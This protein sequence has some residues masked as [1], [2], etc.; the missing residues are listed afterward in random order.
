MSGAEIV[1]TLVPPPQF[2][3]A[4][5]ESYRPDPQHPSQEEARATLRE[6]ASF[7]P[8]QRAHKSPRSFFGFGRRKQKTPTA[9]QSTASQ[10]AP[11]Q[12][13]VYLDGGFGVGKT[14]LLAAIWHAQEGKKYFGTF[15]EYTALVGALGYDGAVQSLK[16]ADLVCID[17]FELDD[18]GDTMLMTRLIRDLTDAGAKIV[19]TSNTPPNALGEGRFAAADFMREIHAMSD[20]FRTLRIDGQDYRQRNI[21]GSAVQYSEEEYEQ[22]LSSIAKRLWEQSGHTEGKMVSDDEFSELLEHLKTVHPSS[23]SAVVRDI[24]AIGLRNVFELQDQSAA[25]RFVAFI[26]RVYD[27]Q[28]PMYATGVPLTD[29]FGG[30][31]L[32]GGYRKKY[33]RCISRV[34]AL[35]SAGSESLV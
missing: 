18:P 4:S 14:H 16:D 11:S 10:G 17:E 33:L 8:R 15:I 5:F 27:A 30:G 34:N 28:I 3:N 7:Q 23:Y 2:E 20:R 21:E 13:G 22:H 6:F 35:T 19:A 9:S 12:A 32:D 31:M 1:A 26:D 24:S 25:L 29:I